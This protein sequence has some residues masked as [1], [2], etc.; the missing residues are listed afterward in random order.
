[1]K[2]FFRYFFRTLRVIL[3]PFLLLWEYITPP[4]GIERSQEEQKLVDEKTKNITLYQYPT[5]PFCIKVRRHFKRL[6]LNVEVLNAQHE[7]DARSEL[8][9]QGGMA[10]VPCLRIKHLNKSHVD[11]LYESGDIISYLNKNFDK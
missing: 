1:M 6:S 5:C 3:G 4:K 2:L 7:G 10:Q 8:L 9:E 11:W